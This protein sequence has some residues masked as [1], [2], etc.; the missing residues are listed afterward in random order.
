MANQNHAS[1]NWSWRPWHLLAVRKWTLNLDWSIYCSSD[2]HKSE[3]FYTNSTYFELVHLYSLSLW[4]SVCFRKINLIHLTCL[5]PFKYF[6]SI[7]INIKVIINMHSF[8]K[9]T[10]KQYFIGY[11]VDDKSNTFQWVDGSTST[12]LN[13][14]GGEPNGGGNCTIFQANINGWVDGDCNKAL[15]S[16]C[17]VAGNFNKTNF[18]LHWKSF[19]LKKYTELKITYLYNS[20]RA[21]LIKSSYW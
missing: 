16:I 8:S 12:Y 13:W 20:I 7:H 15:T 9:N 18:N 6:L 10:T 3:S 21:V 4:T 19:C 17:R 14:K 5:I 11:K 2:G 1:P